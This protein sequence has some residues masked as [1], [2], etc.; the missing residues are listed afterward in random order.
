MRPCRPV[1]RPQQRKQNIYSNSSNSNS[2]LLTNGKE[3]DQSVISITL[4]RVPASLKQIGKCVSLYRYQHG[5]ALWEAS[6]DQDPHED[7][8][9]DLGAKKAALN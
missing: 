9:P 6:M 3:I 2:N 4:V 1:T 5:S 7:V 8:T